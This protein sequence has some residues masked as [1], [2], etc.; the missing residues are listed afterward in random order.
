MG[1]RGAQVDVGAP[2]RRARCAVRSGCILGRALR[3]AEEQPECEGARANFDRALV[4][5]TFVGN[6][7]AYVGGASPC[8]VVHGR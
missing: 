6:G 3:S 1:G 2:R 7:L 8:N 4:R 5:A